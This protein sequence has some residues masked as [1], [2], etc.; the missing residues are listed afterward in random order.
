MRYCIVGGCGYV[1]LRLAYKLLEGGTRD[2]EVVLFDR[3]LPRMG[4]MG[5]DRDLYEPCAPRRAECLL[6]DICDFEAVG[7]AIRGCECVFHLAS[8]GMSGAESTQHPLIRQVNIEGTRNVIR[9]CQK[10]R[11]KA[12]VYVST[13]NV[14]FAGKMIKDGDETL[15][16]ISDDQ[17][18]DQ[19]SR[20]KMLA[21]R[22]VLEASSPHLCTVS[23]RPGGIW[24][25]GE[26]RHF[27]RFLSVVSAGENIAFKRSERPMARYY[28]CPFYSRH[29]QGCIPSLLTNQDLWWTGYTSTI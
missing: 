9:A 25:P 6:G 10:H 13:V 4:C 2:V 11:V 8:F 17:D 23:L 21:E 5:D 28:Y 3:S 27:P 14:V 12:L 1:G 16:Y 22:L 19:Y 7:L 20:S 26:S 18:G 24:G 15:P 29:A